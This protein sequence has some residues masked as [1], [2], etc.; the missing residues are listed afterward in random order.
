MLAVTAAGTNPEDPLQGLTVGEHPNPVLPVGW[1]LVS[2][3]ASTVNHHDLWTLR[4]IGVDPQ[5]LP[6]VLGCDAAGFTSTGRAVIVHAVIGTPATGW[7]DGDET[8]AAD[9]SLLSERHDGTMAA[10]LAVPAANLLDMPPGLSFEDAACLPTAYLTAYRAL[11]HQA[12]LRPGDRVLIQGAGGGVATA[13]TVLAR[14]AGMQ[15]WVTSRS[16]DKRARA[17]EI[18]AHAAFETGARLPERVHAVIDTVGAA[19]W[20]HSQRALVPGGTLVVVGATS[21]SNPPAD[22][23]RIF[24]RQLRV[25]G[26]T[27]G[28][29]GELAGLVRMLL[30]TGVRPVIDSIVPLAEAPHAFERLQKGDFFGKIVLTSRALHENWEH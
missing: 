29:L 20:A 7:G 17:R 27:M 2:V 26:S 9:M 8:L 4:G 22:L 10:W 5:R 18:G 12:H 11:F 6:M 19:T 30:A 14:A 16:E 23:Q 25:V 24:Y 3:V 15:V 1:E 13:A 21:G 28:T